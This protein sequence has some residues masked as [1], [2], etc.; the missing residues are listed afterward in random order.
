MNTFET[1]QTDFG[2]T[3]ECLNAV[4]VRASSDELTLAVVDSEVFLVPNVHK[5]VVA[6]P[7]VTVDDAAH[8]HSAPNDGL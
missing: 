1:M 8:I 3:P 6:S 7:A 4:D 5:T 2:E